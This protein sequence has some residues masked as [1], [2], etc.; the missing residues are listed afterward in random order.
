MMAS[1][2]NWR[3]GHFQPGSDPLQDFAVV[4]R[5]CQKVED[6]KH[7]GAVEDGEALRGGRW[8]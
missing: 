3:S 4:P 5:I 7:L 1:L 2:K 6:G 8:R